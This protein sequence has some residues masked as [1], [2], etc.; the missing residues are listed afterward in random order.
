MFALLSLVQI[1]NVAQGHPLPRYSP[2]SAALLG[3]QLKAGPGVHEIPCLNLPISS[4]VISPTSCW[5]TS[6][7]G[8]LVAGSSPRSVGAGAVAV[9]DGQAQSLAVTPG[10]GPLRVTSVG[11]AGAC[12]EDSGRA[13][14]Q[15]DLATGA[16]STSAATSCAPTYSA[17]SGAG[18]ATTAQPSSQIP[19]QIGTALPPAVVPSYYEDYAY[20]SSACSNGKQ[21]GCPLYRQGQSTYTPGSGGLLVLDFGAPCFVP[22]T[23]TYGAQM[24]LGQV[25]VPDS[26]IKT[27]VEDWIAG[28]ESD[29]GAGTPLLTLSVGTSNS[30]NGIDNPPSYALTN[31]QMQTS[32]QDWYQQLVAAVDTSG[33][34]APLVIWGASD[35]EQS[36][37]GNWYSGTPTVAWMTGYG[38]A[39]PAHYSCSLGTSG[40]VADYGDDVLGG[41]GSA[42]GWTVGQVYQVAWGIPAACPLP[43]I[44]YPGMASE[45]EALSQWGSRTPV[46]AGSPSPGP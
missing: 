35:M 17:A 24:F 44:Y 30:L 34:A 39:S 13:F 32:G 43:E 4:A 3:A 7:T 26:S 14:R 21:A 38:S 5:Q 2:A 28:Y 45:W 16:L 9:I 22:N 36:G 12:V 15:V 6:P 42:Y 31:S 11:T 40:F 8:V 27:L 29:H 37:S 19:S 41:G 18:N 33:L 46:Q 20:Y 1:G 23:S 10:T 25:C